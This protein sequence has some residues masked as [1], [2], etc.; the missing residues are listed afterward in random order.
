[1][2]DHVPRV[3]QPLVASVV[4][5]VQARRRRWLALGV[6]LIAIAYVGLALWMGGRKW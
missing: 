6:G 3:L 2:S 4:A 1:M 5:H